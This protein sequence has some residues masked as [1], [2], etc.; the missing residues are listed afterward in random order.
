MYQKISTEEWIKKKEEE[1]E[2]DTIPENYPMTTEEEDKEDRTDPT[3]EESEDDTEELLKKEEEARMTIEEVEKNNDGFQR[4]TR[5]AIKNLTPNKNKS[6]VHDDLNSD[7]VSNK[8]QENKNKLGKQPLSPE[9]I[10]IDDDSDSD[11][12]F[13]NPQEKKDISRD[14]PRYEKNTTL[15]NDDSESDIV[16]LNPT[17]ND[18]APSGTISNILIENID[19]QITSNGQTCIFNGEFIDNNIIVEHTKIER[20][21]ALK[22]KKIKIPLFEIEMDKGEIVSSFIM[23]SFKDQLKN[24]GEKRGTFGIIL[25]NE[26]IQMND[27]LVSPYDLIPISFKGPK[28]RK[29]TFFEF[30]EDIKKRFEKIIKEGRDLPSDLTI[31]FCHTGFK[32]LRRYNENKTDFTYYSPNLE[33]IGILLKRPTKK[34]DENKTTTKKTPER[35]TKKKDENIQKQKPIKKTPKRP[36]KKESGKVKTPTKKTNYN[37]ILE[38]FKR[39][40]PPSEGVFNFLN[41]SK[42]IEYENTVSDSMEQIDDEMEDEDLIEEIDPKQ[43]R[44]TIENIERTDEMTNENISDD[45]V[46][47]QKFDSRRSSKE[48]PSSRILT[49]KSSKPI[50]KNQKKRSI[51]NIEKSEEIIEENTNE[52]ISN[53]LAGWQKLDFKRSSKKK[54]PSRT[55]IKNFSNMFQ[56]RETLSLDGISEKMKS[57]MKDK[58]LFIPLFIF[59]KLDGKKVNAFIIDSFADQFENTDYLKL[60]KYLDEIMKK[61]AF[62]VD[63]KTY[64]EIPDAYKN[65]KSK[66][67]KIYKFS[68]RSKSAIQKVRDESEITYN[69]ITFLKTKLI[70][71]EKE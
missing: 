11:I 15:D 64:G 33:E 30:N 9:F 71:K 4:L 25:R 12:V 39:L 27:G 35:P 29:T 20:N 66:E 28:I 13:L 57:G 7:V 6:S 37:P 56:S 49:K 48:K 3:E 60:K 1:K 24:Y 54:T 55:S 22:A 62:D 36:T 32:I 65:K 34:S 2:M 61:E 43:K 5:V 53:D 70:I 52:N 59:Q 45:I 10:L 31:T 21:E 69:D 16:F 47:W 44:R 26:L 42:N 50:E 8:P 67:Y 41:E 23:D 46:G 40:V 58:N 14:R 38:T 19:F 68:N 18:T 51:K 17:G 63:E